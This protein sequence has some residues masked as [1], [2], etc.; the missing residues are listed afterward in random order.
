MLRCGIKGE[1]GIELDY[2]LRSSA[3]GIEITESYLNNLRMRYMLPTDTTT[4]CQTNRRT[5]TIANRLFINNGIRLNENFANALQQRF[6]CG[7]QEV[8]FSARIQAAAAI[9]AW[10]SSATH[11]RIRAI[12]SSNDVGANTQAVL[13]NAIYFKAKWQHQFET[14]D[15]KEERFRISSAENV[16]VP[17][18]CQTMTIRYAHLPSHN[19][20]AIELPYHGTD[21]S[22]LVIMPIEEPWSVGLAPVSQ[23]NLSKVFDRMVLRKVRVKLPK[24][25][26]H[27]TINVHNLLTQFGVRTFFKASQD[28]SNFVVEHGSNFSVSKIIQEAF[29]NVTEEGTEAAAATACCI[30]GLVRFDRSFIANRPFYFCISNNKL[31]KL[32]DGCYR[33][34]C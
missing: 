24:F 29:I 11:E 9:N 8:D 10:V 21:L 22:M 30:D 28:Y 33:R 27:C 1:S 12:I 14:V 20:V 3:P 16:L 18:M 31:L 17:M 2:F 19:A 15:T 32:F 26:F 25:S 5:L 34:P 6:A 7:I 23:L 4:N 13:T